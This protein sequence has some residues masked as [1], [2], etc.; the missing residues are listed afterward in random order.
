MIR[1]M[2]KALICGKMVQNIL[3]ISRTTIGT[4][5]D[6]CTGRMAKFTRGN[7]LTGSKKIRS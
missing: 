3:E 6:K 4:D 5:M 1:K 7:G 2:E